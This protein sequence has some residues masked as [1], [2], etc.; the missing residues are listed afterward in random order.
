VVDGTFELFRAHFA[1]RPPSVSPSGKPIRA[2]VGV[3][4]SMLAML[5]DAQEKP[6]HV[7]IAFDNP[8]RSFRNDLFDGYK[9]EDGV[10]AEL[11]AQ[12]DDVEVGAAA[13]GMTVWSMKDLEADDALA[14]AVAAYAPLAEVEQ[15]R[16]MSPDKDLGQCLGPKV[17][18]IDRMRRK[19]VDEAGFRAD[20]GYAPSSVPDFLA[21]VGDTSDGIPGLTGWGEKSTGEV[22]ARY[23]HLEDIPQSAKDWAVQPRGADKLSAELAAHFD[24]ALLYRKLATLRRDAPMPPLSALEWSGVPRERFLEWCKAMG[25]MDRLSAR[26]QRWR[27]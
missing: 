5:D 21:L 20:K 12:F 26:P 27:A 18:Q 11:L 17:V 24:E 16:V 19:L 23:P 1:K 6:T 10:P 13:L 7:A 3:V 15:V 22:L 4:F 14:S 2:T 8:I 9:T 25:Q